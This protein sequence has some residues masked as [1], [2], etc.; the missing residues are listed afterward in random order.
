MSRLQTRPYA[1]LR[2]EHLARKAARQQPLHTAD[3]SVIA[4][5]TTGRID[6][7]INSTSNDMDGHV[8]FEDM[9]AVRKVRD[10]L[11]AALRL[12]P[13]EGID[14]VPAQALALHI[15]SHDPKK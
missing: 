2:A 10:M 9:N 15:F 11:T 12:K 7:S 14:Q 5:S 8:T 6:L 13:L 1:A 3:V 4:Y